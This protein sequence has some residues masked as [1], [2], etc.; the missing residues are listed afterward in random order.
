MDSEPRPSVTQQANTI[1]VTLLV[2]A[3]TALGLGWMWLSWKIP[4]LI[5]TGFIVFG[6][7]RFVTPKTP[8]GNAVA[9]G[10][11]FGAVIGASVSLSMLL[12]TGGAAV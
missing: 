1:L 6:G 4:A 12:L 3:A 8:A 2:T 7:T 9:Q 5:I 10:L 11:L